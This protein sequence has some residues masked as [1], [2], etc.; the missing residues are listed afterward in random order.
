MVVLAGMVFSD[1]HGYVSFKIQHIGTARWSIY[2]LRWYFISCRWYFLF[3]DE[4]D[5]RVS[6]R[7]IKFLVTMVVFIWHGV[8]GCH[9]YVSVKIHHIATARC[10][11]YM[12]RWYFIS[13]RWYFFLF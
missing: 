4:A 10:S 1:G 8:F 12:L 11:I 3:L 13:C 7:W 9:G 5:D 6:A 2:M